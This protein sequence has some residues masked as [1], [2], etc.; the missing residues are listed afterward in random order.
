MLDPTRLRLLR[1]LAEYGTMTAVGE[2]NGMT[3]SAVSQ[4]L[5]RLEREAGVRLFHR[6]GRRVRLTA[7]GNRLVGHAHTVLNALDAAEKDLREAG[8][9]R[10][11][12]RV[13]TFATAAVRDLLPAVRAARTRF[14]ELRVVIRELEPADAV[15]ALREEH[16]DL[17]ITYAYSLLPE[18]APEGLD[19]RTVRSE[20]VLVALPAGHPAARDL[21]D[22][23]ELASEPWIVGSRGTADHRLIERAAALAGFRPDTGHSAD[24]Y[25]LILQMVRHGLGVALVPESGAD[26]AP[27]DVVLRPLADLP[28]SRAVHALTR[29]STLAVRAVLDLLAGEGGEVPVQDAVALRGGVQAVGEEVRTVAQGVPHVDVVDVVRGAPGADGLA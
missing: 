22:L 13:A 21:V 26:G 25:A 12:V 3:S 6:A 28:L 17:A 27:P 24:D 9:P 1:D 7:E 8:T 14:P 5:A 11:P 20:P 4:H 23:R 16:C 15:A 10:G 29:H 2:V 19:V 18:P